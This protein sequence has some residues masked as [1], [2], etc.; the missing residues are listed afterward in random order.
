MEVYT[1]NAKGFF[2]STLVCTSKESRRYVLQKD[3]TY[4]SSKCPYINH[5]SAK[6]KKTNITTQEDL[7]IHFITQQL[8]G[9]T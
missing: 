5:P 7:D 3:N 8:L 9:G 2:R 4:Y 1:G 6:W